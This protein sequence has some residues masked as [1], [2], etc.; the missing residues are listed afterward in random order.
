[1]EN[2]RTLFEDVKT[3]TGRLEACKWAFEEGM[4]KFIAELELYRRADGE[5]AGASREQ[6]GA[7]ASRS[8]RTLEIPPGAGALRGTAVPG[9]ERR[10]PEPVREVRGGESARPSD[11][12]SRMERA[13]LTA[14]AQHPDGLS[15]AQI[16]L[17]AD[18][19]ASGKVS[20]AFA[21]LTRQGLI[22]ASG[23]TQRVTRMGLAALGDY[24]PLPV[25]DALREYLLGGT[26]LSVMEKALLRAV[27][28]AYPGTVRKGEV[29]T[30]AGYAASGKVSS[31][32]ARLTRFGYV[33]RAGAG[34]LR[35]NDA[36][37]G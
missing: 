17:H 32:F 19:A 12:L 9:G 14:L 3:Y 27:C 25:G 21:T 23:G 4:G 29:L 31:A 34:A 36:L 6:P 7:A 10:I 16:L 26:K 1:M 5:R 33:V 22:E 15:K 8:V 24:Q 13:I 28:D 20:S 37:F 18:Y 30:A 35:A 2:L 11:G